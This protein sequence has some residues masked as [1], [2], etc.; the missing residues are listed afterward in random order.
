ML[1]NNKIELI[2]QNALTG[3]CN[4]DNFDLND[5]PITEKFFDYYQ[6]DCY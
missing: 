2:G 6:K 1:N 3:S 5:N 4:L